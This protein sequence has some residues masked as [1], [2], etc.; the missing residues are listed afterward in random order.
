MSDILTNP[1]GADWHPQTPPTEVPSVEVTEGNVPS[2]ELLDN[3][4]EEIS[5]YA[6]KMGFDPSGAFVSLPNGK[7]VYV[8]SEPA[9]RKIQ[10]G[11]ICIGRY[12]QNGRPKDSIVVTSPEEAI[13]EVKKWGEI[14]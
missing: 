6:T 5:K 12:D 13:D 9:N 1:D 14:K 8:T 2:K 7:E 10:A 3:C 4:L 11:E